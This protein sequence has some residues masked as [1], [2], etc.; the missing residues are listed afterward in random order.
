MYLCHEEEAYILK[1]KLPVI[2]YA[3]SKWLNTFLMTFGRRRPPTGP[4]VQ[5]RPRLGQLG[6]PG[7]F[8]N[9]FFQ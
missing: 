3:K 9:N 4:D 2:A 7:H 5:P 6:R 1:M 8:D